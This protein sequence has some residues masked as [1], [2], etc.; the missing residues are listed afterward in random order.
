[1]RCLNCHKVFDPETEYI[2]DSDGLCSDECRLEYIE[3]TESD[4]FW[5][6]IDGESQSIKKYQ[7]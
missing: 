4:E 6:M 2:S 7:S 5:D 1:M 3:S